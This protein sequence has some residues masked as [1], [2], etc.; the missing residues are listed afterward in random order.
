MV[1]GLTADDLPPQLV[2]SELFHLANNG[3]VGTN[4]SLTR[5]ADDHQPMKVVQN[6]AVEFGGGPG[7]VQLVEFSESFPASPSR[8]TLSSL[9][10]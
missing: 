10:L 1:D 9:P 5:H 7:G 6:T 2:M 8:Y 3:G 4:F